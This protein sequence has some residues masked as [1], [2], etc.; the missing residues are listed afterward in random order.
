MSSAGGRFAYHEATEYPLMR[1]GTSRESVRLLSSDVV[2]WPTILES[3][4]ETLKLSF[5]PV[6]LNTAIE[7]SN[8]I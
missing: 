3:Q 6:I 4:Y 2:P 7:L 5:S 8:D 1:L